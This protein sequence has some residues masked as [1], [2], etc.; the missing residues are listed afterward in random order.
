MGKLTAFMI[1]RNEEAL[2]PRCLAS[3]CGVVDAV[4]VLDTGSDDGTA[5]ILNRAA[6]DP[7]GPPLNWAAIDFVDFGTARRA[8]LARVDTE[9][10]LWIDADEM[11]SEALRVRIGQLRDSGAL[12]ECDIWEIRLENR[13]LGRR[14]RGRNLDGHHRPRLF[15]VGAA[16]I[17]SSAVHEGLRWS[18][19]ARVGKIRGI[20]EVIIHD[21]MTSWRRY[22]AK[23]QHYTTLEAHSNPDRYGPLLALH[24]LWTGPA[25]LGRQYI[26]QDG[27]RDGW[28]GLVW[29]AITA[30]SSILRDVKR[31]NL[32][33]RNGGAT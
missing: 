3:L 32:R 5:A 30:W 28:R 14:M 16:T 21:T 9:W 29:A 19:A 20:G 26:S 6:A 23:V 33:W 17:S 1:V 2:L 13:V 11:V 22:L 12:E 18:T 31:L 24:L 10:A 25:T 8:A 7:Q 4:Q 27:W 15:R